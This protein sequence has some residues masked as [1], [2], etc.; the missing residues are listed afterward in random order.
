MGC[1]T[2]FEP[3]FFSF[4]ARRVYH[5]TTGNM[6]TRL[7]TQPPPSIRSIILGRVVPSLSQAERE[8]VEPPRLI[9]HVCF[10]DKFRRQ[11]DCLSMVGVE[12]IEPPATRSQSVRATDTPY[13]DRYSRQ[14]SNPHLRTLESWR[15]SVTLRE[16]RFFPK[17]SNLDSGVQS[18]V[19]C[20]YTREE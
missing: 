8:G 16:H 13:P 19:C 20:H 12:G 17:D 15:V 6:L 2:G 14:D 10:Q 18:A 3:V 9:R 5:Y 7:C 4:T 1:P 11:S